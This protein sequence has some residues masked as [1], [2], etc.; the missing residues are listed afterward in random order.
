MPERTREPGRELDAEIAELMEPFA[1]LPTITAHEARLRE[2]GADPEKWQWTTSDAITSPLGWW[3]AIIGTDHGRTS[4]SDHLPV[5]W[6][7]SY[8]REPS[9][10]IAAAWLVV[11]EMAR[12]GWKV[13]VQNRYPPTWACHV[14][15]P[16]PDYRH[17]FEHEDTAPH[18]ISLAF[19]AALAS[20][21]PGRAR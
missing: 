15:F 12:R 11:E 10:D 17:V 18:A 19:L 4:A 3:D 7:L 16:A 1:S 13:D 14:N 21:P 2:W 5:R 8:D 9:T 20:L 6:R